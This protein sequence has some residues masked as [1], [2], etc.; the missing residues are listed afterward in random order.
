MVKRWVLGSLGVASLAI[1]AAS[2]VGGPAAEL[3]FA[4][5]AV[6]FP[7]A[8]M[9][10]G[11][12]KNGRLGSAVWPISLLLLLLLLSVAGMLVFRGEVVGAP[13]VL[14]LPPATAVQL[15]GLF[16]LPLA[17]VALG[18]AWTFDGFGPTWE[19]LEELRSVGLERPG[20]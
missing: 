20:S 2:L 5:L 4:F 7:P 6:V 3:G 10:L 15:L 19:E 17:V 14:G 18:F 1:L 13:S 8:L 16:V 12:E 11:V 9:L